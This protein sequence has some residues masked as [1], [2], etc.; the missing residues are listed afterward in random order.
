MTAKADLTTRK[1]I[2]NYRT[3]LIERLDEYIE[4]RFRQIDATIEDI[5]QRAEKLKDHIM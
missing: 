4:T 1:H 5:G 3:L 2:D